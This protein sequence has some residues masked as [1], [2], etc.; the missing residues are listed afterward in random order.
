MPGM[1]INMTFN[2]PDGSAGEW[3]F[4]GDLLDR[5]FPEFNIT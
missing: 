3:E 1:R 5:A 2:A 4:A